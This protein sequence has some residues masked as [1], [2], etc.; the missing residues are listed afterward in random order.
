[1]TTDI[2][3]NFLEQAVS[4]DIMSSD[5]I[6]QRIVRVTELANS[7]SVD[8]DTL[9][10]VGILRILNQCDSQIFS[11]FKEFPSIYDPPVNNQV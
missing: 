4:R 3:L 5:T 9:D 11:G 7:V 1:M 8:I 10:S 6:P 2:I